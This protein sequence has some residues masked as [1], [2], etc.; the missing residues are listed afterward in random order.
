M[1]MKHVRKRIFERT[2]DVKVAITFS[3]FMQKKKKSLYIRLLVGF[4]NSAMQ[5]SN[6]NVSSFCNRIQL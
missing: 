4:D 1:T 5:L 2:V 6:A 3:C